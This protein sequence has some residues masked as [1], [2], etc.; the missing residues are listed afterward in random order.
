MKIVVIGGT[1]LI[2]SALV[3]LLRARGH[4]ALAASPRTGVDTLSG[5]G[6]A[7]ALAGAEVLVDVS[8]APSF[9]AEPVLHFFDTS[10]RHQLAAA[11]EAGVRHV[12]ALS[13]VGTDRLLDSGYFRA[14]W[15]QEQLIEASGLPY[16]L[17]RATQFH[18][19][20][21]AIAASC[22]VDGTVRVSP[23]Q[24]Q[25]VAAADVAACL[26]DLA[27]A[28][29]RQGRLELGGPQRLP[30]VEAVRR[31]LRARGD[32]RPVVAEADQRYFGLAVDDGSL[33]AGPDAR[34]GRITLDDWL[35]AAG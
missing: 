21:D 22:D 31:R 35:A 19:F 16:T 30:M 34:R 2:G 14:K 24:L 8:N 29:P 10:T 32:A 3:P 7:E 1:G 11:R 20:L 23:A 27:L 5:R 26:A 25:P 12:V 15:R 33:V 9:E 13:V 18:E 28:A 4:E 17:L 6:L